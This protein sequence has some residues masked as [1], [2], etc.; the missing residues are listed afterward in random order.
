[1]S[2]QLILIV[3][4][5]FLEANEKSNL[6]EMKSLPSYRNYITWYNRLKIG[7]VSVCGIPNYDVTAN[8]RLGAII[9][10]SEQ[11]VK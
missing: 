4:K 6:E 3:I 1:V 9:R 10:E 5:D 11:S 8:E 2:I 7:F